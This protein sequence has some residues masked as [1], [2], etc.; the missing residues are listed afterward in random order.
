MILAGIDEA[1]YGPTLGP[2]AVALTVFRVHPWDTPEVAPNLWSL[3]S[4]GVCK[5]PGRGGKPDKR[6][7]VAI[8]D[9]K[10]LKLPNSVKS[11]HPLVHLE[12]GVLSFARVLTG[13]PVATDT[14][15]LATFGTCLPDHH[16]YADA[17][18]QL[19]LAHDSGAIGIAANT[20]TRAMNAAGIEL[21]AMRCI[22]VGERDF[23]A[24]FREFGNKASTSAGPIADH[25]RFV[26]ERWGGTASNNELS[27]VCDRLG[28]RAAYSGFLKRALP[29]EIDV[30]EESD[31]RSRYLLHDSE[32][33]AGVTFLVEGESAHLPVALAS[34]IAKYT[35]ELAM[36]R[37]NRYWSSVYTEFKG[38]ELKPTAGYSLDARRWLDDM[39]TLLSKED[40]EQLVRI[41]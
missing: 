14:D 40:R 7:R 34:M 8:A 29:A 36:I 32:R 1:G 18:L 35:R 9:S 15:C 37:F 10:Q 20:L 24:K 4:T 6:G 3:L 16:S 13:N 27:I 11:T 25:L 33:R 30:L 39:G 5:E 38:A 19:P 41:A 22:L 2:L 17:V 12:R 23:N 28:G 26:W 21:L 31:T